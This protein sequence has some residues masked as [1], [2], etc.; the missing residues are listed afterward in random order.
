V[1]FPDF[2]KLVGKEWW[3]DMQKDI[4]EK[5]PLMVHELILSELYFTGPGLARSSTL[6]GLPEPQGRGVVAGHGKGLL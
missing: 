1:H 6:P 3:L 4:Y 5:L 2:L